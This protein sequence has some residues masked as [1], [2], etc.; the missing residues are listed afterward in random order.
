MPAPFD[1]AVIGAGVVGA[2]VARAL[3]AYE[4]RTVVNDRTRVLWFES[5]A[6]PINRVVDLARAAAVAREAKVFSVV[7][8]T[9]ATPIL[10]K[11][12]SHGID[13]VMHSATMAGIRVSEITSAD[14]SAKITVIA[15]GWNILPSIPVSASI[16]I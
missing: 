8:N 15:I 2:A 14:N 5:P 6:N 10:Q 11:P 7:D 4:L 1:V 3:S 16:G 13:A 12:I 9:F